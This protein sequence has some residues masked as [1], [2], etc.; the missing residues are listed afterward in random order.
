MVTFQKRQF[1]I[2]I[3]QSWHPSR[4]VFWI[5]VLIQVKFIRIYKIVHSVILQHRLFVL[6][7]F[8]NYLQQL[9][10]NI[11]NTNKFLHKNN[12]QPA[13]FKVKGLSGVRYI[14][15]VTALMQF[16]LL[17]SPYVE[18]TKKYYQLDKKKIGGYYA[19]IPDC[20]FVSDPSCQK[21][22]NSFLKFI[23]YFASTFVPLCSSGFLFSR[24][25][26]NMQLMT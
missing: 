16:I 23:K 4:R 8:V 6:V 24:S 17:P 15:W 25:A 20:V 26:I 19:A 21:Q 5:W 3:E 14:C 11:W 2:K 13:L 10:H 22:I 18:I 12:R 9:T 1:L 7:P